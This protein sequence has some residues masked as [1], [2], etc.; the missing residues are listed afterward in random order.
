[1]SSQNFWS[2]KNLGGPPNWVHRAGALLP[3][4]SGQAFGQKTHLT[5][6]L[7]GIIHSYS[8]AQMLNEMLQNAD[9]AGSRE[10]KV[11]LDCRTKVPW[12][13]N[14]MRFPRMGEWQGPALCAPP[15]SPPILPSASRLREPGQTMP[16]AHPH[17]CAATSSKA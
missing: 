12:G 1:V 4:M 6:Q 11:L 8:G 3:A 14:N 5:T 13:K 16:H 10:F 17:A 2:K 15:R 9:D 7:R